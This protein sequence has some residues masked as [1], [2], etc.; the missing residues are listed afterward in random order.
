MLVEDE[1]R[2]LDLGLVMRGGGGGADS[3]TRIRRRVELRSAEGESGSSG[4]GD[5]ATRLIKAARARRRMRELD[6]AKESA[7]EFAPLLD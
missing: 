3:A 7:Y 2:C 4:G 5:K 6:S 1:V